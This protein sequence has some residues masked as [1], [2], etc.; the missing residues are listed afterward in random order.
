MR[1]LGAEFFVYDEAKHAVIGSRSGE[2]HR[3]GDQV[4]VKLVEAAPL[5]GA[6]RFEMV[7]EGRVLP[8]KDRPSPDQHR[9]PGQRGRAPDRGGK[10]GRR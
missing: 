3:L 9:R 7:S 4:E 6:L 8:R 2:M 10:R 5:A 1:T